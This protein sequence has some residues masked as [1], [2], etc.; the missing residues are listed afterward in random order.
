VT[1]N[2]SLAYSKEAPWSY[3]S[4]SIGIIFLELLLGTPHVFTVDQVGTFDIQKNTY[5]STICIAFLLL[6]HAYARLT[7]PV[8]PSPPLILSVYLCDV[9]R[10]RA[11]LCHQLRRETEAARRRALLLAAMA[12]RCLKN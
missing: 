2:G 5:L 11:I 7:T 6:R 4:W 3:D 9:Q 12:G 1:L 10:T 8:C